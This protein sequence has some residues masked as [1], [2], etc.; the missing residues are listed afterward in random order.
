MGGVGVVVV[1]RVVGVVSVVVMVGVVVSVG[2]TDQ[3][4]A[5]GECAGVYPRAETHQTKKKRERE[6]EREKERSIEGEETRRR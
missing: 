3:G 2:V 5:S 1:G 6:R 4:A